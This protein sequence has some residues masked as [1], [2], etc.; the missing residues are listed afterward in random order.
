[1]I[2]TPHGAPVLKV[3]RYDLVTTSLIS[4]VIGLVM[5]IVSLS[6]VWMTNRLSQ[7]DY[8]VPLEL[9]EL[10]GGFEAGSV[11]ETLRLDSPEQAVRDP[12]LA[13][14]PAEDSEIEE[15]LENVI[16]L[17]EQASNQAQQIFE[18]DAQNV[19]RAGSAAGSGRRALGLGPGESGLPRDQ[20]WF[21][22]FSERGTL[23]QYARQL[24]FF[25]IELGALIG[26]SKI[27]YL[28]QLASEAPVTRSVN[29][30]S[31]EKRLYMT[32]QGGSRRQADIELF[33]QAGIEVGSATIFHFYPPRTE[34]LLAKLERDY[35][36]RP[37]DQIRRTYY[38][39]HRGGEE[40]EFV[41]SR[42]IDFQ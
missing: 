19:G 22:R 20:R 13:D 36:N 41:V 15:T 11:D 37:T 10:A 6:V 1:M 24:D 38:L 5:A 25:G 12:S 40:F 28:T 3:T 4:A 29:S 16:E 32:W 21:V 7:P 34:A 9:L 42:Q 27:V 17:A 30:G 23:Q 33:R 35:R 39:V 2:K 14:A 31:G 18:L 26:G 8:A